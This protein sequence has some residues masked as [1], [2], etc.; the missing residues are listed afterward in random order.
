MLAGSSTATSVSRIMS[1]LTV[2]V[3]T[4]TS[5]ENLWAARKAVAGIVTSV[6]GGQ[7]AA[8]ELEVAVG[9]VLAN[10]YRHG[11]GGAIGPVIIDVSADAMLWTVRI[12]DHGTAITPPTIPK[13]PPSGSAG[14]RG[15]FLVQKL[16]DKV[17]I[18]VN[19][20]TGQGISITLE[21][22]IETKAGE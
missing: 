19:P 9:E 3:R 22:S 2:S 1:R 5:L 8:A 14:G 11:Y 18:I 20:E 13:R 6:V 10:A 12:H 4:T 15:L 17:T 16:V 21:K 7:V